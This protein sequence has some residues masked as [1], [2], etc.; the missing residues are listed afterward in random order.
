MT[1][2]NDKHIE[3]LIRIDGKVD[4]LVSS[5]DEFKVDMKDQQKEQDAKLS[6]HDSQF[7]EVNVK[8][9]KQ[10]GKITTAKFWKLLIVIMFG[11]AT[12][13]G[14]VAAYFKS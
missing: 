10:D 11:V 7:G 4:N 2:P 14:S 8:M 1:P 6:L 13:L 9:A 3:L 12:V 5:F